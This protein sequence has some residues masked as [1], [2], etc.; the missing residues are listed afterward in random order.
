M[1]NVNELKDALKETLE[2]RGVLNQIRALMRQS[3]F[4]AIESS[5]DKPKPK[6]TDENLIINELIREYLIY[7]NYL[8]TNSVFLAESGQPNEAFDRNFLSKELNIVEDS[9]SRKLP[10]L[11]SALFG[12]KK[13]S[14]VGNTNVN[15]Y[16]INPNM[17]SNINP[18]TMIESSKVYQTNVNN[19]MSGNNGNEINTNLTQQDQPK[20]WVIG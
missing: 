10:L 7:N 16:S 19:A 20:P 15:N 1:T 8:H 14:Y 11:Y 12:L 17:N 13:E 18:M 9:S 2:E 3:I 6:L 4:E 5:D